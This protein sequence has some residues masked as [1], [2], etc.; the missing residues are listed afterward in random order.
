[1]RA[2]VELEE[3][4]GLASGLATWQKVGKISEVLTLFSQ[5]AELERAGGGEGEGGG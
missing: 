5:V 2:G 1:M 3:K 4:E